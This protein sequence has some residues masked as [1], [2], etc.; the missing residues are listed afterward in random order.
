MPARIRVFGHPDYREKKIK[1][2]RGLYWSKNKRITLN[3]LQ[4]EQLHSNP[5]W[6]CTMGLQAAG[7][8]RLQHAPDHLPGETSDLPCRNNLNPNML[9]LNKSLLWILFYFLKKK[10]KPRYR[11][12]FAIFFFTLLN[13]KIW[14]KLWV[15]EHWVSFGMLALCNIVLQLLLYWLSSKPKQKFSNQLWTFGWE[16]CCGAFTVENSMNS[17]GWCKL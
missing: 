7:R 10:V 11:D 4:N 5:V 1:G 17:N 15:L 12:C 16:K 13:N 9:Y 3:S 6:T 14:W 8:Q 2:K